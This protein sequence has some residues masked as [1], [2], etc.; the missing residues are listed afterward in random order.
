MKRIIVLSTA[1]LLLALSLVG[2]AQDKSDDSYANEANQSTNE[3]LGDY[4]PMIFIQD[5]LYGQTAGVVSMFP[6]SAL[7]LGSIETVLPQ[8]VPMTQDNHT[9]NSAPKGSMIYTIEDENFI[10]VQLSDGQFSIYEEIE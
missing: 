4:R 7:V 10:Y 8:N 1:T 9:S 2:C 3:Q 6:I 5:K